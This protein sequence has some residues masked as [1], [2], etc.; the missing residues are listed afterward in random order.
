MF[1]LIRYGKAIVTT[2]MGYLCE[3]GGVYKEETQR[4]HLSNCTQPKQTSSHFLPLNKNHITFSSPSQTNL[5]Q[6]SFSHKKENGLHSLK[7]W[8]SFLKQ[9]RG[10]PPHSF[11]K[12]RMS[13]LVVKLRSQM[14]TKRPKTKAF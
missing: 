4:K 13:T 1:P 11:D 5:R 3:Q 10:Q 2:F 12:T 9:E 6:S 14:P 8:H 7:F